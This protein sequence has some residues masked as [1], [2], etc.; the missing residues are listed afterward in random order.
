MTKAY[1]QIHQGG[2][3]QLT[4]KISN[5][6]DKKKI[7][8]RIIKYLDQNHIGLLRT[9]QLLDEVNQDILHYGL[10]QANRKLLEK[11]N[12]T[13][14]IKTGTK[15]LLHQP[16]YA[17]LIVGVNH[18]CF[19]DHNIIWSATETD[20]LKAMGGQIYTDL[21]KG[22]AQ[23]ILPILPRLDAIDYPKRKNYFNPFDIF[24]NYYAFKKF[25]L[26]DISEMNEKSFNSAIDWIKQGKTIFIYPAGG[27]KPT[28]PWRKGVGELL[29]KL[30]QAKLQKV[31]IVPIYIDCQ[32]RH[33]M[34]RHLRKV[35]TNRPSEIETNVHILDPIPLNNQIWI[36]DAQLAAWQLQNLI[37]LQMEELQKRLFSNDL[38]K[39]LAGYRHLRQRQP[40]TQI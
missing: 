40:V 11:I 35:L 33:Q 15:D 4:E 22:Y 26:K 28:I 2:L 3:H 30:K 7:S 5:S 20:D 29:L 18:D 25:T 32:S 13:Y 14:D 31:N 38:K 39:I 17:N 8:S 10:T 34:Q 16:G 36:K 27:D 19:V 23:H 24:H 37:G 12:I 9:F 6:E 21:G 1:R